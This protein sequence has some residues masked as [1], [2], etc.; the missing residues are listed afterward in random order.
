MRNVS[1]LHLHSAFRIGHSSMSPIPW[2]SEIYA[3]RAGAYFGDDWGH[4]FVLHVPYSPHG[5]LYQ[6]LVEASLH[7]ALRVEPLVHQQV[8]HL[9]NYVVFQA[10]LGLVGLPRPEVGARLLVDDWRGHAY[11]PG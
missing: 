10:H 7:Y 4:A 6:R 8:E 11:R 5:A 3:G 2:I 1:P 9:V